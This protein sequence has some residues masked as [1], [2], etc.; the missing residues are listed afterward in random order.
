MKIEPQLLL[1]DPGCVK[2]L[3]CY[4][5]ADELV[6]SGQQKRRKR[7]LLDSGLLNLI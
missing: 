7:S 3:I 2:K 1:S 4:I 6:Q 5:H